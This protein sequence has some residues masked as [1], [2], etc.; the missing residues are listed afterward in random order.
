MY[1]RKQYEILD[2]SVVLYK[3]NLEV[4][5]IQNVRAGALSDPDVTPL[6][7][8]FSA[9]C[10]VA[11]SGRSTSEEWMSKRRVNKAIFEGPFSPE[12]LYQYRCLKTC[13]N[14]RPDRRAVSIQH[15]GFNFYPTDVSLWMKTVV[16]KGGYCWQNAICDP[17]TCRTPAWSCRTPRF[18]VPP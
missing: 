8:F 5:R 1:L 3:S 11:M 18:R 15:V 16:N 4:S 9:G 2:V 12:T 6:H 14:S 17:S 13:R 10:R 7:F